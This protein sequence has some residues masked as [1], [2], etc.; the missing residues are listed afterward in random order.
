MYFQT[1]ILS[2]EEQER[3]HAQSLRLLAEAGVRFHGKKAPQVFRKNGLSFDEDQLIVKIPPEVVTH[4]LEQAP[5]Q[6]VLA[7]RNPLY[8]FPMPSMMTRYGL[9]GTAA[10]MIDF[11]TGQR[12]YGTRQ[13]IEDGMR[14]FQACDMGVMA[15]APTCAEDKPAHTRALHEFFAMAQFCSKHGQHELHRIEQVPYLV[16]GLAAIAGD[17]LGMEFSLIYCPVAPLTH[18]GEMLDAYLELGEYNMP[19]M[20]M[21]MPVNGTT[22]PASL[23]SNIVLANAEALSSIVV[24]QLAHPGRPLI[25]A[26]ATGTVDFRSGAYLAGVPEMGL[27][28][29]ALVAMG[30]YY[31]LPNGCAGMTSDAKQPGPEAVLEKLIT[32]IPGVLAGADLIIGIGEIESD[33][34]LVLEQLLVDNEIAHLCQRL[35]EGIDSSPEMD[36]YEDILRVGPGGH[37]LSSKNT[38]RAARSR[39][40]YTPSLINRSAYD[41]WINLGSPSMYNQARET[42]QKILAEPVVDPLP[43]DVIHQL[44][45]ILL[46]AEKEIPAT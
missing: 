43:D 1:T 25:Y 24:F 26:S 36:F 29:A 40:F 38:R 44:D 28:S 7:A 16:E 3:V 46:R 21:P 35:F 13:D 5:K 34:A 22:G 10:F 42:V 41:A 9:D 37:F 45:E 23:F 17:R 30:K 19:V 20:L 8:N 39:E 14:V 32:T 11:H 15:W 33:Q 18:D 12:R 31:H 6:F 27:Q 2:E 4:A